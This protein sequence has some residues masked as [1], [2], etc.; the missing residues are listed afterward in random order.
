MEAARYHDRDYWL[1]LAP[2]LH[3]GERSLLEDVADID[4]PARLAAQFSNDGYLHGSADWG[5]DLKLMADTVRALSDANV[6]I[7]L[8]YLYD[9]FWQPFFK[10]HR[11]HAAL[12]GDD[13]RLLPEFSVL[14]VDPRKGGAG[15]R[16]HRDKGRR[17]LL[18]DGSPKSVTT[19]ITLSS[20]TPLNGCIYIVPAQQDPT[21]ATA[22]E[23]EARF[24][25]QSIRAL[26][27]DPGDF[28]IW[29]QA[30]FHWGGRT[31][32]EAAESRVSMALQY[33]RADVPPFES[34]LLD[35]RQALP[36]D[37]RLRLI[38]GQLFRYRHMYDLDPA[39]A[40]LASEPPMT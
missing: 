10:L 17:A 8:A 40:R 30:L 5:L 19:W 37:A 29:N 3:I 31:S 1:A 26:P 38:A 34:P 28:I 9:E 11:F 22:E 16:P 27:G 6:P 12:L 14:N 23:T 25:Y 36:F 2:G 20:S 15:W 4:L 39:L 7:L 35:P 13:Y 32:P 33:Q 21:Y 24:E 18:D